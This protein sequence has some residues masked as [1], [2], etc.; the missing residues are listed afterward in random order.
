[1][2]RENGGEDWL[3]LFEGEGRVGDECLQKSPVRVV[4]A[5]VRHHGTIKWLIDGEKIQ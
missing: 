3:C 4:I 5:I 1:M 2:S